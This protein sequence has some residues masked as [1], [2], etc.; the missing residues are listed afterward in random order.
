MSN[1]HP[2]LPCSAGRDGRAGDV[3]SPGAA[4]GDGAEVHEHPKRPCCSRAPATAPA[5]GARNSFRWNGRTKWCAP[6]ANARPGF[7][8]FWSADG[9][10][11]Q[12]SDRHEDL[13]LL[14]ALMPI[15]PALSPA[16]PPRTS[17]SSAPLRLSPLPS[18][19][20]SFR[21][22]PSTVITVRFRVGLRPVS[23]PRAGVTGR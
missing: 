1:N 15:F 16:H 8:G 10:R 22:R 12:P 3:P 5:P 13:A 17:V 21:L 6:I 11:P 20:A 23:P 7:P 2:D 9:P 19:T 14:S 18:L 4:S